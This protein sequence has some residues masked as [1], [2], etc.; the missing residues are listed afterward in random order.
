VM[1]NELFDQWHQDLQDRMTFEEYYAS[2]CIHC[3]RQERE[4][5][6]GTKCLYDAGVYEPF[7]PDAYPRFHKAIQNART[8][9]EAHSR[10]WTA[11]LRTFL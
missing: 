11:D 7:G 1:F 5:A 10:A 3:S 9:T 8:G 6:Y 2:T 4:H